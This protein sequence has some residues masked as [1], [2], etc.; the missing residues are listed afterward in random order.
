MF[1]NI[2]IPRLHGTIWTSRKIKACIFLSI[3]L[4]LKT[5]QKCLSSRTMFLI[6]RQIRIGLIELNE[7][8]VADT[9]GRKKP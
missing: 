1:P 8:P 3:N 7:R 4:S 5:S 9:E 6:P 2:L